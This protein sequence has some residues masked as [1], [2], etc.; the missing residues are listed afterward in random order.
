MSLMF[1]LHLLCCRIFLCRPYSLGQLIY[2]FHLFFYPYCHLLDEYRPITI[3]ILINYQFGLLSI[4]HCFIFYVR[5]FFY[6]YFIMV[7]CSS[8]PSW[9]LHMYIPLMHGVLVMVEPLTY[10]IV[11]FVFDVVVYH[12][13]EFNC[14]DT[15]SSH[16]M[17]LAGTIAPPF[18]HFHCS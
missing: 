9:S 2:F 1:F 6:N 12:D 5:V 10:L 7:I 13:F 8:V 17:S 4:S 16:C 11:R 14:Y 18:C 15:C 3:L